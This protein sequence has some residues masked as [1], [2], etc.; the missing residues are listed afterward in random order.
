MP[1]QR[2]PNPRAVKIHRSY[3]VEEAAGTLRVH[4]NTVR[5]WIKRGLPTIDSRRPILINGLDL[6]R[7]LTSERNKRKQRCA[8]GELYCVRCRA[9]KAPAGGMVDYLPITSAAGNLRGLCPDC[10]AL[11][12]RRVSLSRLHAIR[13]DMDIA[14]PQGVER[15]GDS[16]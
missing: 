15:I 1:V 8:M 2:R 13:G 9:P 12:H 4:K 3:T 14:F 7:F 10:D 5:A 6:F 11:I 16:S